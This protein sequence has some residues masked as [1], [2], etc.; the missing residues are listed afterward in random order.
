MRRLRPDRCRR[1]RRAASRPRPARSRPGAARSRSV[2]SARCRPSGE[3]VGAYA[4]PTRARRSTNA[5]VSLDPRRR[6]R[7]WATRAERR[8]GRESAIESGS[9]AAVMVFSWICERSARPRACQCEMSAG[10]ARRIACLTGWGYRWFAC[11]PTAPSRASA[12]GETGRLLR[13]DRLVEDAAGPDGRVAAGPQAGRRH[14]PELPLPD[15][16]VVGTGADQH[17]QRR[18]RARSWASGTRGPSVGR[19]ARAGRRSGRWWARR[20]RR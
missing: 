3:N 10:V 9:R 4:R 14:L 12:S 7:R 11:P 15:V 5:S 17:L 6:R 2:I 8:R 19:R 18:V 20:P 1:S 13:D 16:R